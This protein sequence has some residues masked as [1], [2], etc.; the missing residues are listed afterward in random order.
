LP[1]SGSST[2]VIL[3]VP[4]SLPFQPIKINSVVVDLPY[5]YGPWPLP[6]GTYRVYA[7]KNLDGLEYENPDMLRRFSGRTVVLE[8]D[9]RTKIA[10]DV[11]N[12]FP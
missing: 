3:L 2:Q 10:L 12:N 9:K 8:A 6:P 1:L 7:F 11:V 5:V 4:E